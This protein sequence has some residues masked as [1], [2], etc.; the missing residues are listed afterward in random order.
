VDQGQSLEG[1]R[2][3]MC[4]SK[5]GHPVYRAITTRKYGFCVHLCSKIILCVT[6]TL[7]I[8]TFVV[9]PDWIIVKDEN[10]PN[11]EEIRQSIMHIKVL[12]VRMSEL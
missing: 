12:V 2:R 8:S 9:D 11:L 5:T 3:R 10:L 7:N 4:P 1:Q 6:V